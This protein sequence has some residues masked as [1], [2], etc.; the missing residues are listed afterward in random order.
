MLQVELQIYRENNKGDKGKKG[1]STSTNVSA[2]KGRSVD[3]EPSISH[4]PASISAVTKNKGKEKERA[5]GLP[6]PF[7]SV[8]RSGV[9]AI[10]GLDQAVDGSVIPEDEEMMEPDM[11][12]GDYEGVNEGIDEEDEAEEGGPEEEIAEEEGEEDVEDGDDEEDEGGYMVETVPM[13]DEA[14]R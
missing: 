8:P 11:M 6:S 7:T 14:L 1:V 2:T 12:E 10:P 4:A 13:E 9:S 5:V 3:A